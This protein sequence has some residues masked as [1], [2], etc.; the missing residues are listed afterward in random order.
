M[1]WLYKIVGLG[2]MAG[3]IAGCQT[4]TSQSPA[5]VERDVV[6]P[7]TLQAAYTAPAVNQAQ[8]KTSQ[9]V[10][11][12]HLAQEKAEA[13]LMPIQMGSTQLYAIPQPVFIQTHL[14]KVA[15]FTTSD[16]R[17]FL[18]F[19]LEPRALAT[20]QRLKQ[21]AQGHYLLLSVNGQLVAVSQIANTPPENQLVVA[22]R[23]GQ[24]TQQILKMLQNSPN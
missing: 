10:I 22:M 20:W 14:T 9:A 5:L 12:F 16:Q 15:P 23:S 7:S 17:S 24:Q 18:V 19:D 3:A 1:Q 6:P 13:E 8:T 11:T 4:T 21:E 2:V